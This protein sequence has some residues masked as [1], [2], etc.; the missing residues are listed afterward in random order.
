MKKVLIAAAAFVIGA[1][2]QASNTIPAGVGGEG[3]GYERTM[4]VVNTQMKNPYTLDIINYNGSKEIIQAFN[5]E[6]VLTAVTQKDAMALYPPTASIGVKALYTE[7]AHYYYSV[8]MTKKQSD[9]KDFG[10]LEDHPDVRV[11]VVSDSGADVMISNFIKTDED[12][13]HLPLY[14]NDVYDALD[15]AAEGLYID[16]MSGEEIKVVG[17]LAVHKEGLVPQL[18]KEDFMGSLGIGEINDRSF[19]KSVDSKGRPYYKDCEIE[20]ALAEKATFGKQN[21]LCVEAVIITNLNAL[22]QNQ[23]RAV[24]RAINRTLRNVSK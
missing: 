7:A 4:K 13:K 14:F 16:P 18:I 8:K 21:T 10:S 12:Y 1:A 9:Y 2:A 5:N 20:A 15:A 6:E 11:A 3:L 19:K 24:K 22:D 23:S 17:Y